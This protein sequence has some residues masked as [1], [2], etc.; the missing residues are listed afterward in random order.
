MSASA[1]RTFSYPRVPGNSAA[2]QAQVFEYH[3][4]PRLVTFVFKPDGAALP[5]A[6]VSSR[7][8]LAD[9]SGRAEMRFLYCS[10]LLGTNVQLLVLISDALINDRQ[11]LA[12]H[13]S[14]GGR[15]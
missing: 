7:G 1:P 11:S 15:N 2:S 14:Q 13:D 5:G 6:R 8:V 9:G 3:D 12:F 10:M 4:S